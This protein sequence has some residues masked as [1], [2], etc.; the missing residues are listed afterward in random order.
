MKL[1]HSMQH[2]LFDITHDKNLSGYI[3]SIAIIAIAALIAGLLVS[4]AVSFQASF[5]YNIILLP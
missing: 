5:V 4:T 3:M 2:H 1:P